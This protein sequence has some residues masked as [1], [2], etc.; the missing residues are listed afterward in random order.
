MKVKKMISL[1]LCCILLSGCWDKIEIDRRIFVSVIGIDL[2][3]DSGDNKDSKKIKSDDPFQERIQ[4]KKLSLIY[5]FPDISELG[6]GKSGTA[7]DQ[8]INVDA[9]SMEDGILQA[10]G[11]SSRSIHVGQTKLILISSGLLEQPD[12]FKEVLDYLERHPNLNKMMQV[13][14]TEGKAEDYVKF[15]PSMEK[16]IETYLSG[17]M[18][19]SK[20]NSTILPV[21]LNEL[22]VLLE[23]NGNAIIPKIS[24]DKQKND[25]TLSGVAVIK[26]YALKGYM[27]PIEVADLE[28]MRGKVRGGKRVIYKEGHPIDINIEDIDRK[29]GVSGDKNKLKFNINIRLEG[30]LREYYKSKEV[31]SKDELNLLEQDFSK[32][33]STEC[34]IIAKM[35][36]KEFAVDP[37]GLREYLEQRKP[38]L[39][40]QVENNWEEVYKNSDIITNA[41]V[42]IRRIGVAK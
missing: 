37:I 7:K 26:N 23:Q 5:G 10:T 8:Y 35:L 19:S 31:F 41:D 33:I 11:R 30:Q 14:V 40:K 18:E 27:T 2:G 3:K 28:I 25:I 12:T 13:V 32:S 34:D 9:S 6:P 1:V 38:S 15:K 4:Q 17:L 29:I 16:N 24:I 39:W 36:Q 20:R 42:K 21:T 22:I